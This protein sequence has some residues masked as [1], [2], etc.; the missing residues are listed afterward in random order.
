MQCGDMLYPQE[1]E[2]MPGIIPVGLDQD[3]HIRLCRDVVSRFKDRKYFPISS[4]YHKF[5]PSLDGEVKMS[6]SNPQSCINLPEDV[7]SATKKLMRCFTGGRDSAEEQRRLGGKPEICTKFELDKQHLIEDDKKLQKI[8]DDCKGGKVLCGE[9]KKI[10][11]EALSKF[12][13]KLKKDI[14]KYRK[15]K[16]KWAK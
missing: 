10:S 11:C 5:T 7:K 16:L 4:I 12:M 8:Y 3:P 15:V 14:V 6:K 9:C 1:K 2:V 13:N